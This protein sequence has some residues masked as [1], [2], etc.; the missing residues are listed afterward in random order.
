M[1]TAN[2]KDDLKEFTFKNRERLTGNRFF[3]EFVLFTYCPGP[4]CP[5]VEHQRYQPDK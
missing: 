3:R 1:Q 5:K 2:K 4:T